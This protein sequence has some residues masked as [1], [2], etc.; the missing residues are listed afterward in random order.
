MLRTN[1]K[2]F[3]LTAHR[4]SWHLL[5]LLSSRPPL[6]AQVG[7]SF[8]E[9]FACELRSRFYSLMHRLASQRMLH[10]MTD[11]LYLTIED[12]IFTIWLYQPSLPRPRQHE[13][14]ALGCPLDKQVS[15]A[16]HGRCET[17]PHEYGSTASTAFK[18]P[19]TS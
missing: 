19:S 13:D 15:D 6:H 8:A 1:N 14:N 16:E 11:N 18:A 2:C 7:K 5:S 12:Y 3:H 10:T 17:F 4:A 9:Q